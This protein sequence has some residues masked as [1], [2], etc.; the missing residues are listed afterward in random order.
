MR[1]R[2]VKAC[3]INKSRSL[4]V[5]S[6]LSAIKSRSL[7]NSLCAAEYTPASG[8]VASPGINDLAKSKK[9]FVDAEAYLAPTPPA[10]LT[11][12][13]PSIRSMFLFSVAS[14]HGPSLPCCVAYFFSL[15]PAFSAPRLIFST[16]IAS[17]PK[18]PL[19]K[20]ETVSGIEMAALIASIPSPPKPPT[21]AAPVPPTMPIPPTT[22]LC[23]F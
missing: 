17:L 9:S 14:L 16:S 6:A 4:P 7:L 8:P 13:V 15:I 22:P 11:F 20:D 10:A 12:L 1:P 19:A 3:F 21:T 5:S 23:A 18:Y 2:P